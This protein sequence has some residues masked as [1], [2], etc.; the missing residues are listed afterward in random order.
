MRDRASFLQLLIMVLLENENEVFRSRYFDHFWRNIWECDYQCNLK[1]K[2]YYNMLIPTYIMHVGDSV[3]DVHVLIY[4][5]RSDQRSWRVSHVHLDSS[6]TGLC[7][8]PLLRGG[9]G[10]AGA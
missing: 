8:T 3:M 9:G 2:E 7:G 1:D 6:P 4:R 5:R 10:G